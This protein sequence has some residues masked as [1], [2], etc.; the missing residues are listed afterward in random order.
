MKYISDQTKFLSHPHPIFH[1]L[2][3]QIILVFAH[4][5]YFYTQRGSK[6]VVPPKKMLVSFSSVRF[7]TNYDVTKR[8]HQIDLIYPIVRKRTFWEQIKSMETTNVAFILAYFTYFSL[9]MIFYLW[10]GY[11]GKTKL[12]SVGPFSRQI[13]I[14]KGHFLRFP[15]KKIGIQTFSSLVLW[16]LCSSQMASENLTKIS[17]FRNTGLLSIF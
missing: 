17:V 9:L 5:C 16:H 8:K 12:M 1:I 2:S 4:R 7:V 3:T 13:S 11:K 14:F 10:I 6:I 15:R